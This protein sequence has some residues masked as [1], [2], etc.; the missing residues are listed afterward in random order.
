MIGSI[1]GSHN[2]YGHPI[3]LLGTNHFGSHFGR[4]NH[5]FGHPSFGKPPF[6]F[7]SYD[8]SCFTS[9]GGTSTSY[10]TPMGQTFIHGPSISQITSIL[11]VTSYVPLMDLTHIILF[12]VHN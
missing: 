7:T 1:L 4:K 5:S 6:P 9:H 12:L 3:V 11:D 2:L 10:A 8:Q